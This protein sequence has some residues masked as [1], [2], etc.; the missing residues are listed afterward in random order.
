MGARIMFHCGG[1]A[2]LTLLVNATTAAPLLRY[3]GLAR[4]EFRMI[5]FG[6]WLP[7]GREPKINQ[8]F[9]EKTKQ[10]LRETNSLERDHSLFGWFRFQ[11][12]FF[13]WNFFTNSQDLWSNVFLTKNRK[14]KSGGRW[15][16]SRGKQWMIS[17]KP[18]LFRSFFSSCLC[19]VSKS[20]YLNLKS[21]QPMYDHQTYRTLPLWAPRFLDTG[22]QVQINGSWRYFRS[23]CHNTPRR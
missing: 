22:A 20:N 18:R 13:S 17:R 11:R 1:I 21:F 9:C 6:C 3:L 19:F 23:T 5:R 15:D 8:S 7:P 16:F 10:L 4:T 14:E 2:A 12:Y